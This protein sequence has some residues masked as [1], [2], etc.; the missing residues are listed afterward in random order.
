MSSS[1]VPTDTPMKPQ[2]ASHLVA[3]ANYQRDMAIAK[4]ER[5]ERR[6]QALTMRVDELVE[7]CRY[8]QA[9]LERLEHQGRGKRHAPGPLDY[10]PLKIIP[11]KA[12]RYH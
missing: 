10:K 2:E 11:V 1:S 8:Q 12:G 3:V 9:K 4:A 7:L 6:S 5:M